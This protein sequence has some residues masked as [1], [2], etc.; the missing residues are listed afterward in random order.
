MALAM[1]FLAHFGCDGNDPREKA[2]D[3]GLDDD[4]DG[5]VD[6]RDPDC[7]S[8]AMCQGCGNGIRDGAEVC[9]GEDFGDEF[10]ET[11]GFVG[12]Y[13]MC[14]PDC[15]IDTTLCVAPVCGD[16]IAQGSEDCDGY[17][18]GDHAS[19]AEQGFLGGIVRC[20]AAT[21]AYD[22][23]Q[24]YDEV[25]CQD[26]TAASPQAPWCYGQ[27]SAS[28]Y[29]WVHY[30][31]LDFDDGHDYQLQLELW[32]SA[33][34]PFPPGLHDLASAP[35]D[36]YSTCQVCPLLIQCADPNC[37]YGGRT[38]LPQA[39]SFEVLEAALAN[40]GDFH[41]VLRDLEWKEVQID[42]GG[43]YESVPIPAGPCMAPDA[44][45]TLDSSVIQPPQN[46]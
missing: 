7:A 8:L 18:M 11:L 22:T 37:V 10:C 25:I 6:C 33:A 26:V 40:S 13:L 29:V 30:E 14:N 24:C 35:N 2:C 34:A 41:G 23:S 28:G 31:W 19:C 44:D 15:T 12:G 4:G 32:G 5:L 27:P 16:G 39:G 21:C 3:N 20:D 38:F 9:D 42:W 17:D 36:N 43:T 45:L 46:P 1:G